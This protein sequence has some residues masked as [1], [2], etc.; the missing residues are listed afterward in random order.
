M[1]TGRVEAFSDGVMAVA[2]T[3]LVLDLRVPAPDGVAD[4]GSRLLALWPNYA[5]YAISFLAIGIMW[6]NHHTMLGRLRGVD[7]SI[8]LLNLLLL[9]CIV[10]LPF[11]TSLLST[12]L[13]D[14][15]AGRLAAVIYAASLLVTSTVFLAMQHHIL[16]RRPQLLKDQLSPQLV[17]ALLRRAV[18]APPAYVVAGAAGLITPVLT[19]AVCAVLGVLY[20]RSPRSEGGQ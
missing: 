19:L 14:P 7:R 4:L 6:M 13:D 1:G 3:L 8:L 11:T 15:S 18:L 16:T 5:A 17:R 12:Y 2:I 10:V 20:L 9:M